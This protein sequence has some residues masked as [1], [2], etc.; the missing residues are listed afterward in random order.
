MVGLLRIV[1]ILLIISMTKNFLNI[2]NLGFGKGNFKYLI[3]SGKIKKINVLLIDK[4]VVLLN[5]L[6]LLL[7]IDI[8]N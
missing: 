5:K 7:I 1:T 2:I 8:I 6:L 3:Y 4:L